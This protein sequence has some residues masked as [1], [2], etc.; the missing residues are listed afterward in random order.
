[1]AVEFLLVQEPDGVRGGAAG[2]AAIGGA[3]RPRVASR[4]AAV[5]HG[6]RQ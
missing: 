6:G 4:Y 5:W 3:V 1:M 2:T